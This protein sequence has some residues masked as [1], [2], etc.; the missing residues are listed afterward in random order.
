MY[1][2][3]SWVD[4]SRFPSNSETL[5]AESKL[6]TWSSGTQPHRMVTFQ[7]SE[8]ESNPQPPR[9]Q[10]VPNIERFMI[11]VNNKKS[12]FTLMASINYDVTIFMVNSRVS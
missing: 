10:S 3:Y 8:S 7:I 1:P 4:I 5:R 11:L 6:D 12:T 9:L 2:V